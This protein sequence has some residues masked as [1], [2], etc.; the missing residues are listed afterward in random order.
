MHINNRLI[1]TIQEEASRSFEFLR[2]IR[3]DLH[4]HP[5]LS[6][7]ESWT[8][9][10]IED[11]LKD[12]DVEIKKSVGGHGLVADL[13]TDTNKPTVAFRVDMDALPI[14][15]ANEVSYK[16]NIRG[17]MH[18]CGHDV[19]IAIGIGTAVLL[20]KLSDRLPGNIRFIFQPEEEQITGAKRMIQAGV[21]EDPTPNAIYGL[22]V[23]PTPAGKIA[24]TDGL[25]LAG[26]DHYLATLIPKEDQQISNEKLDAAARRCC[27]EIQRLNKWQLPETWQEMQSF[28]EYLQNPPKSLR[29]FIIYDA[30]LDEEDPDAWHGE[31]GI[32][33]KAA[34]LHLRRIALG[35]IRVAINR[36]CRLAKLNYF[37][38][39]M[40]SMIDMHN[41][42]GLV[43][44]TLPA[45]EAILGMENLIPLKAAFPFNC[46]DFA[47]YTKI[48]PGAMMWLGAANPQEEKF[49][50]LHTPD[51]DVD[52][53]CLVTGTAAMTTLLLETLLLNS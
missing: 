33:V 43:Q 7:Q 50:L 29:N 15:E 49:A 51:F 6:G 30:S 45:L 22:H 41:D 44:S 13:V 39:P 5:E 35:R 8:A 10:Y 37:I 36:V 52:E 4:A 34:N 53:T 26:F 16:S 17:V 27:Q 20:N 38:E 24:W 3:R 31:F 48:I 2:Q 32:G 28:W 47:Y 12:L 14:Q 23:A 18:A 9:N 40:G 42:P 19:H 1:Q 11:S 25:F 46:E 21:L